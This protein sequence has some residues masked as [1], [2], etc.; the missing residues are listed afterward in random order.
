MLLGDKR[1][2]A[3][4]LLEEFIGDSVMGEL[5]AGL[6]RDFAEGLGVELVERRSDDPHLG[7]KLRT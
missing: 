2:I 4:K 7:S 6:V 5:L 1:Q 3:D